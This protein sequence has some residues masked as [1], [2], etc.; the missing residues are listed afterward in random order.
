MQNSFEP[1]AISC[2]LLS[3][4]HRYCRSLLSWAPLFSTTPP[5]LTK[6]QC[7]STLDIPSSTFCTKFLLIPHYNAVHRIEPSVYPKFIFKLKWY[8]V[9]HMFLVIEFVLGMYLMTQHMVLLASPS[10][11]LLR[12]ACHTLHMHE[13]KLCSA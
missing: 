9:L 13:E 3:A 1:S 7:A 2:H 4:W 10:P 8:L 12:A 6:P 5:P 11:E